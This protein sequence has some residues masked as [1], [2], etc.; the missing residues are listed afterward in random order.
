MQAGCTNKTK[1]EESSI[2]RATACEIKELREGT[3]K[4]FAHH[5]VLH[6]WNCYSFWK[7]EC[8]AGE[9]DFVV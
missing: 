8:R 9:A 6:P 4:C 7:D 2:F 1:A 3:R 5:Q